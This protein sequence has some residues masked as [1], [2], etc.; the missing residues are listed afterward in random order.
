MSIKSDKSAKGCT[1]PKLGK[2]LTTFVCD[3]NPKC[4]KR[5]LKPVQYLNFIDHL[6]VCQ[7]CRGRLDI[8]SKLSFEAALIA[9]GVLASP[10]ER[11][12]RKD[13]MREL[14]FSSDTKETI[15]FQEAWEVS[16]S[17]EEYRKIRKLV[18]G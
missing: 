3:C 4:E 7:A 2:L 18:W 10:K 9:W 1:K 6:L 15:K 17:E 8:H 14:L 11:E 12:R 13:F 5:Q 16:L